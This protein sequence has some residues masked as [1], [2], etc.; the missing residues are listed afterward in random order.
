M[1]TLKF[2]VWSHVAKKMYEVTSL[3]FYTTGV[4]DVAV[5]TGQ[6]P[7]GIIY[8][9]VCEPDGLELMQFTGLTDKN[10]KEIFEGDILR[11][12][13][14]EYTGKEP[15]NGWVIWDNSE[16]SWRVQSFSWWSY[17]I[18]SDVEII[19]NVHEN[20]DLPGAVEQEGQA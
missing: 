5:K 1:R 17:I 14:P 8:S 2:R 3:D 6:S 15:D 4:T 18:P 9:A 12:G 16:G 13:F 20:H 7:N 11:F 19:S 10:G